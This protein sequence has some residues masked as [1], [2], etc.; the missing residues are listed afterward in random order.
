MIGKRQYVA[1]DVVLVHKHI[2][3][4]AADR[5]VDHIDLISDYIRAEVFERQIAVASFG[6]DDPFVGTLPAHE[7]SGNVGAASDRLKFISRRSLAAAQRK[8]R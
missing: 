7:R 5:P 6:Y 8:K 3:F 1:N 4:R 2:V